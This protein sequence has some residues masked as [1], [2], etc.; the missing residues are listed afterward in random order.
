MGRR[1]DIDW[2]AI[3]RDYRCGQL[4]IRQIAE[5]YT[6]AVSAITRRS[7]KDAWSRDLSAEVAKQTKAKLI[8]C[9]LS[10]AHEI[11]TE[12]A[13][14]LISGVQAAAEAN[15]Q[16]IRGH[17]KAIREETARS[18]KLAMKVDELIDTIADPM[19]LIKTVQAHES[20]VRSRAK[21]IELERK[22]FNLDA[23]DGKN[24]GP[25]SFE[26]WLDTL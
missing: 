18:D 15:I 23:D 21:L 22:A 11:G 25:G 12:R 5:R 19:E 6:V 1:S 17:K 13:H 3:E 8:E 26:D 9:A 16:V 10:D 14:V 7:K 2:E 20:L 24:K 4:S